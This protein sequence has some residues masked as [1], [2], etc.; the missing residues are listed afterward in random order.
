MKV[1]LIH[2]RFVVD[3]MYFKEMTARE[4]TEATNRPWLFSDNDIFVDLNG[5][6]NYTYH[7]NQDIEIIR[8]ED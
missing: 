2:S 4:K 5:T 7:D 3:A 6:G 8:M 1:K